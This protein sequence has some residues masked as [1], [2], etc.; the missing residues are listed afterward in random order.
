MAW[1]ICADTILKL[2]FVILVV[3]EVLHDTGQEVDLWQ[4]EE[5]VVNV[6]S[7]VGRGNLEEL[8]GILHRHLLPKMAIVIVRTNSYQWSVT[9]RRSKLTV[10]ETWGR[11]KQTKCFRCCP[12]WACYRGRCPTTI[13]APATPQQIILSGKLGEIY[14]TGKLLLY[15]HS[16]NSG[17]YPISIS[18]SL[19]NSN[20]RASYWK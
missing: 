2:L 5:R 14:V 17:G 1:S 11:D 16:F 13:P 4:V 15:W 18:L 12:P 10:S 6:D 19:I 3:E 9:W 20:P 7:A 8:V